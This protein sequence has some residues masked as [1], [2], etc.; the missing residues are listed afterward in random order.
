MK[1]RPVTRCV[2]RVLGLCFV[3]APTGC[4]RSAIEPQD[5]FP[6]IAGTYYFAATYDVAPPGQ[7]RR[8]IG[9]IVVE[10]PSRADAQLRVRGDI[11]WDIDSY[12][13][14]DSVTFV[15]ALI[16][17]DS[18]IAFEMP[19]PVQGFSFSYIGRTSSGGRLLEGRFLQL[20][21]GTML[22]GSWRA[23]R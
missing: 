21:E 10:Q 6:D 11:V 23:S 5:A 1:G 3:I 13:V 16:T 14:H 18:A 2:R 9:T 7:T 20:V 4:E 15:H 22:P 17:R 8:G 19:R 12:V